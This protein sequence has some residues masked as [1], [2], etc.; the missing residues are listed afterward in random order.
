MQAVMESQ[1][2]AFLIPHFGAGKGYEFDRLD[3]VKLGEGSVM[4]IFLERLSAGVLMYSLEGEGELAIGSRAVSAWI[5]RLT[6]SKLMQ[7][8]GLLSGGILSPAKTSS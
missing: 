4:N 1:W 2:S 3:S 8:C 6:E 5:C 7:C